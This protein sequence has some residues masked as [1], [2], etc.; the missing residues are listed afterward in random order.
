[1]LV[2]DIQTRVLRQFGDQFQGRIKTDDIIRWINDGMRQL[3]IKNELLQVRANIALVA[4]Q[5]EYPFPVNILNLLAVTFRGTMMQGMG[6]SEFL[7]LT[8]DA[9]GEVEGV[10][11]HFT[12]FAANIRVYPKPT[13]AQAGENLQV[14]YLRIPT[15]VTAAGNTP[16]VPTVYHE[17]LVEYCLAQ[18]AE[19]DED[20]ARYQFKMNEFDQR[21]AEL[22]DRMEWQERDQY[23]VVAAKPE[24]YG[25]DSY[26]GVTF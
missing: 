9:D 24:E 12:P 13:S 1:M 15:D 11:T 4:G 20:T 22:K 25:D 8:Q 17:R 7:H 23:P 19:F 18:A 26:Y 5:I 16:E 10:P 21:S 2:S 6:L 14:F 3:V